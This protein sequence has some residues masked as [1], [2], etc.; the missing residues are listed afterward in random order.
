MKRKITTAQAVD[1]LC[2]ALV[3][4]PDYRYAWWCNIAMTFIDIAAQTKAPHTRRATRMIAQAA[5]DAFLQQLTYRVRHEKRK[6]K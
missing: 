5:A 6:N 3:S 4:D 1:T 2:R